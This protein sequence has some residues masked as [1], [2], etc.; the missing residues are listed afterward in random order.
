MVRVL[1]HSPLSRHLCE[2]RRILSILAVTFVPSNARD[3]IS[4]RPLPILTDEFNDM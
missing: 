3:K 1:I 2:S 4:S